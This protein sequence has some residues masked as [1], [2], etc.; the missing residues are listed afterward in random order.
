MS[1][2]HCLDELA[3]D[4][5]YPSL[6]QGSSST[7]GLSVLSKGTVIRFLCGTSGLASFASLKPAGYVFHLVATR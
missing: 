5:L 4:R 6:I 2:Q 1:H 3:R 7:P